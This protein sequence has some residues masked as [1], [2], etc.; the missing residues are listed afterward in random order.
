MGERKKEADMHKLM[1]YIQM[2]QNDVEQEIRFY[3]PPHEVVALGDCTLTPPAL[4]AAN[5]FLK[6]LLQNCSQCQHTGSMRK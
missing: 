6:F 3:T 1:G 2:L 4:I 5:T